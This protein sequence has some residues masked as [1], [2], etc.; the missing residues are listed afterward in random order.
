VAKV[1]S[2]GIP[3]L[4]TALMKGIPRGFTTL[5]TGESGVAT[6]LFAKQFASAN[7]DT[8]NVVFF[9]TS[10]RD[11]EL[12][13]AMEA[14]A[15][16][17]DMRV[18]NLGEQYYQTVLAQQLEISR[19]RQ[20]GITLKDI[21]K[22]ESEARGQRRALD[23]LSYLTYEFAKMEAPFRAVVDSLDFFLDYYPHTQVLSVLRT[24]KSYTQHAESVCLVTM[25]N[26][27]HDAVTQ[28]AVEEIVDCV[29]ELER[30]REGGE[31]RRSLLLRKVRNNPSL[32]GIYPYEITKEGL[33]PSAPGP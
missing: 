30:V 17:T 10:E 29:I 23:F 3:A 20:E 6:E 13:A 18:V 24:I 1:T 27:R 25:M 15:F 12:L 11:Q 19:Y 8:E 14:F 28:A 16:K 22:F 21:R 2:T 7:Q 32:T 4:D 31:F 33:V 5:V 9:T 26:R